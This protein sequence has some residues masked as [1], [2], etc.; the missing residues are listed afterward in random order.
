MLALPEF[1]ESTRPGFG[2]LYWQLELSVAVE[3]RTS[4]PTHGL[5]QFLATWVFPRPHLKS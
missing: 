1:A 5:N 2:K 3:T 4:I